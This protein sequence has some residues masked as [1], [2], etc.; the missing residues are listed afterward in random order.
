MRFVALPLATLVLYPQ[1]PAVA[2]SLEPATAFERAVVQEMSDARVRPRAY[3]KFLREYGWL[4]TVLC[5]GPLETKAGIE[6][7][8]V[9]NHTP[10]AGKPAGGEK[11]PSNPYG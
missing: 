4:P 9:K 7:L 3:A 2:P 11:E 5:Q 10:I 8:A 6:V 1:A